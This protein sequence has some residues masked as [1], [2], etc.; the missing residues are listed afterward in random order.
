MVEKTLGGDGC[1]DEGDFLKWS[2]AEWTLVGQVGKFQFLGYFFYPGF[3]GLCRRGSY[4]QR[5]AAVHLVLGP[6]SSH[7][8]I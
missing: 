2:Q 7:G 1:Q 3:P 6:V 4:L 8:G 5:R